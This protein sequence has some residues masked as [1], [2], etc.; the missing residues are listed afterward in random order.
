MDALAPAAL[1]LSITFDAGKHI[2]CALQPASSMK[3]CMA[4]YAEQR[5]LF[6]LAWQCRQHAACI[7]LCALPCMSIKLLLV[8]L[9]TS[10]VLYYMLA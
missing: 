9:Q 5:L 10:A 1:A 8:C 6:L 3:Q 4:S 2:Q 7:V